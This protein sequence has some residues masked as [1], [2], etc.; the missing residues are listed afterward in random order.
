MFQ[1]LKAKLRSVAAKPCAELMAKYDVPAI[2]SSI[3][4]MGLFGRQK[5]ESELLSVP[6]L[7]F[8]GWPKLISLQEKITRPN[9][10]IEAAL[11]LGWQ[12]TPLGWLCPH[13][14]KERRP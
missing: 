14:P 5:I 13:C 2:N 4:K 3:A 7:N 12:E 9:P 6:I 10:R 8:C 1:P 11:T